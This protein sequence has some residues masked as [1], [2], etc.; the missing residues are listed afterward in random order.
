MKNSPTVRECT[1]DEYADILAQLPH[2][3][4]AI[5]F[6]QAPYYGAWQE[7]DGKNVVY[8]AAYDGEGVKPNDATTGGNAPAIAAGLAVQYDAPGGISFLYCPYGPI[9][10]TWTPELLDALR[11]FFKPIAAR[12]NATFVRLDS[13]GLTDL[14]D[15]SGGGSDGQPV[16]QPVA[17]CLAKTAS[18]QPRAEWLLDL[19]GDQE[20]IWMGMHKHARY[21]VRLAERAHA[22]IKFYEPAKAP[23]DMFY[24]LMQ[25]TS[26]RDSFS[27]QSREYYQAALQSIPA[28]SGFVAICTIDGKPAAASVFAA[29]DDMVHYVFSGSSNDYRKIAPPYF[30]LWNAILESRKR[31]WTVLS[32]GGITDSVKSTDLEGVTGFKKRFGGYQ[33]DHAN[34]VDL[35]YK[36][37]KYT[38]FGIYKRL[39]G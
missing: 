2:T 13:L 34:P 24:A 19:S 11:E 25:T 8:F 38:L 18:L 7:R 15:Q 20:A 33:I 17:N 35:V 3:H 31:G 28:D 23:L 37:F 16:A 29:Y 21:N 36:P 32:F 39:R 6:L 27:I 22:Q 12:S 10:E 30:V 4:E 26:G 14:R 1:A 5:P 9:V